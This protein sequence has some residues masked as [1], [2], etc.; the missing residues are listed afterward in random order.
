LDFS[1]DGQR[2]QARDVLVALFEQWSGR[3]TL[4]QVAEIFNANGVCW[5][6]YQSFTQLVSEDPRFTTAN[7]MIGHIDQPGI[8]KFRA[9]GLPM[10]FASE[11]D[12]RP[13]A[14]PSL[15]QQTEQVLTE[16]L[17]LSTAQF[18]KLV[19]SGVVR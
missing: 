4:P 13:K 15:G 17:G 12:R 14:A 10:A 5:G 16:L 2:Y 3:H 1:E 9:A 18:G 19:D 7:P 6:P 11:P 8:G